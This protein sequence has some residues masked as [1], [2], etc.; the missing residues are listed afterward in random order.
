MA[1]VQSRLLGLPAELRIRIYQYTLV[2]DGIIVVH[3][4]V[5]PLE[6]GLLKTCRQIRCEAASIHYRLNQFEFPAN[7]L[8]VTVYKK[9]CSMSYHHFHVTALFR[10]TR[11][12]A[13]GAIW[14]NTLAW[15]KALHYD[16]VFFGPPCDMH[17]KNANWM[18]AGRLRAVARCLRRRD[19][20]WDDIEVVLDEARLGYAL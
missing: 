16:E 13:P 17:V 7:D 19:M 2:H 14:P 6:P 3:P 5:D 11:K 12:A 10:C 15:L 20:E 18:L 9:F 1:V 8:D 4:S